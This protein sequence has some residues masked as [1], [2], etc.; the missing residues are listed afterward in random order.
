MK[1]DDDDEQEHSRRI[2]GFVKIQSLMMNKNSSKDLPSETVCEDEQQQ[3]KN[4]E[5]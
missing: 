1:N 4:D 5:Q 2:V 3:A